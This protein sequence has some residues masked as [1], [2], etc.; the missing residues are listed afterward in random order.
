MP[1]KYL[2]A[3]ASN[4]WLVLTLATAW[5][6]SVLSHVNPRA[7]WSTILADWLPHKGGPQGLCIGNVWTKHVSLGIDQSFPAA[8]PPAASLPA[9]PLLPRAV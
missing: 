9:C 6:L 1:I 7:L 5:I 2:L 4:S 3:N 8:D